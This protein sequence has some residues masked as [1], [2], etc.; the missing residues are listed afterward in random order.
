VT[1]DGKTVDDEGIAGEGIDQSVDLTVREA[2]APDAERWSELRTAFWPDTSDAHRAEIEEYFSA[3]PDHWVCL[4][5]VASGGH[6]VGIAEVGLRDYAE[7]CKTSP[8]GY[9][10]GIY[11]DPVARTAGVG[12]LL[13]S[14]GEAWA[15][16]RGCAE[17][18]SDRS[19]ENEVSGS[20]HE[21]LGFEEA[22]RLVCYRK[23]L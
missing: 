17:M 22:H 7:R 13:V 1:V 10:E 14:F 3:P 9:L 2:V 12:R 6:V 19:I 11:V 18:A 21:A 8:V 20:F 5:A 4:V 16:G 23:D 15:R